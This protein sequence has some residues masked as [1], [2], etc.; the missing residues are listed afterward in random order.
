MCG[1]AECKYVE[2][3]R[4][5]VCE[6]I[7]IHSIIIL[8]QPKAKQTNKKR[9]NDN[10][11]KV[12]HDGNSRGYER[13][14]QQ[15]KWQRNFSML[16][17]STSRKH[18]PTIRFHLLHSSDFANHQNRLILSGNDFQL[19]QQFNFPIL[20]CLQT[21]FDSFSVS[22]RCPLRSHRSGGEWGSIKWS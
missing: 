8:K 22:T 13:E 20:P 17:T 18:F 14:Q 21:S 6:I 2:R 4:K 15:K 9:A 10:D 12:E 3:E 19:L 7:N 5:L 11:I 16:T 1:W